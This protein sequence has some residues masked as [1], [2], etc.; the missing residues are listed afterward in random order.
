[1]NYDLPP[2][3]ASCRCCLHLPPAAVFKEC[4]MKPG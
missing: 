3:P 2:A 4:L 1:M